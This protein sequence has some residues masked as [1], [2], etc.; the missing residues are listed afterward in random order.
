MNAL[1]IAEIAETWVDQRLNNYIEKLC[2]IY[3]FSKSELM[4]LKEYSKKEHEIGSG[5][6]DAGEEKVS[7]EPDAV[8]EKVSVEP[9]AVEE[10]VS[11]EEP[12]EEKISVEPDAV[13]EKVSV[14]LTEKNLKK[15]KKKELQE[16]CR[17]L[18][19]KSTGKK[20]DLI[21][22]ILN[23]KNQPKIFGTNKNHP[24]STKNSQQKKKKSKDISKKLAN[25]ENKINIQKSESGNYTYDGLVIDKAS[26][27]VI[28]VELDDGSVGSLG[29]SAIEKCYQYKLPFV[30][31][32]NLDVGLQESDLE[33]EENTDCAGSHGEQLHEVEEEEEDEE[34]EVEVEVEEEEE[35]EYVYE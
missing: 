13:E 9:D 3:D 18:K 16:I 22:Q 33:P 12:V 27:K 21:S 6:P 1:Q 11:V 26:R 24:K 23:S 19:L 31:P 14:D 30:M 34:V 35:V 20:A 17:S 10:K 15:M 28:G 2:E 5:E 7:V 29:Q 25:P 4:E 32:D 8:E